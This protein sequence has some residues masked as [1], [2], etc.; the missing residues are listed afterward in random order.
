MRMRAWARF[1]RLSSDWTTT[2]GRLL[3]PATCLPYE[4]GGIPL[5]AL[6][7][8]TASKLACLFSTLLLVCWTPSKEAM[9]TIFKSL[10]VWL[11]LRNELHIYRLRSKRSSHYAIAPSVESFFSMRCFALIQP[12]ESPSK[13]IESRHSVYILCF[14]SYRCW[15]CA[16]CTYH[17]V[18]A[19]HCNTFAKIGHN[20]N[21]ACLHTNLNFAIIISLRL[22][23]R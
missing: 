23:H 9:N 16:P 17:G 4:D 10:L 18:L 22:H 1:A 19:K 7:K 21:V 8:D 5:S 6:P 3:G 20:T 15:K 11:G 14:L 13:I 12:E 2:T